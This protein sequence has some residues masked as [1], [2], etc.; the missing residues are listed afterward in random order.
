VEET[1]S[2][3]TGWVRRVINGETEAFGHLVRRYQRQVVSV[4]YRLLGNVEDARDVSQDAFVRAYRNLSQLDD[5]SRFGAWLMRI[6]SNQAL[7]FRRSRKL[8][9]RV[10]PEEEWFDGGN[11]RDPRSG[12]PAVVELEDEGGPLTEELRSA[13]SR[14]MEKL[15]EKQR[16]ALI[17]FSIEGMPQKD[18]AEILDCSVEL[19]KWNVFQARQKLKEMLAE[20][21]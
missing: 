6:A 17:L 1:E 10:A 11:A 13:I 2:V 9:A 12:R 16:L 8:R 7:N 18:V 21:L 5:P 20:Y 4:A 19:V 15:P 14:A 3:E